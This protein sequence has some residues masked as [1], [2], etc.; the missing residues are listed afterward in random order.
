M[1]QRVR[2]IPANT[3]ALRFNRTA[4]GLSQSAFQV[5][6]ADWWH[7]EYPQDRGTAP[8]RDQTFSNY[9]TGASIPPKTFVRLE[10][11]FASSP[12][13]QNY[14]D[15]VVS[16]FTIAVEQARKH[17]LS[18]YH[19]SQVRSALS[20]NGSQSSQRDRRK[21]FQI[22][23]LNLPHSN[24]I[25][26][27]KKEQTLNTAWSDP[28]VG[29]VSIWGLPGCGKTSL[30]VNWARRTSVCRH[31]LGNPPLSVNWDAI[32]TANDA[33]ILC[34]SFNHQE[35]AEAGYE[36]AIYFLDHAAREWFGVK[37]PPK[38][39]VQLG[40]QLATL[41]REKPALLIL[42]GL[43]TLQIFG[44]IGYGHLKDPGM[45][46]LL[47]QLAVSN[48]GLCICTSLF[49]LTDFEGER[50][51]MFVEL[52]D[53]TPTS[54]GRY[55]WELG[56]HGTTRDLERASISVGNHA[57]S[58]TCLGEYLVEVHD[59]NARA[60][61]LIS[62][63]QENPISDLMQAYEE[64]FLD[65]PELAV[66]YMLSIF[67]CP[68][69][70]RTLEKLRTLFINQYSFE[71]WRAA[72]AHCR[73]LKLIGRYNPGSHDKLTCHPIVRQ[74]F[75]KSLNRSN[76]A[77]WTEAHGRLFECYQSSPNVPVYPNNP[78]DLEPLYLAVTHGCL[79]GRY[80]EAFALLEQRIWRKG[81]DDEYLAEKTL[82]LIEPDL[83]ALRG[84]YE[85][86]WDRLA[87]GL[88]MRD[89]ASLL[90]DTAFRLRAVGRFAEAVRPI[91]L[92]L[93]GYDNLGDKEQ[94]AFTALL[95]SEIY[96]SEGDLLRARAAAEDSVNLSKEA[97][98]AAFLLNSTV[99]LTFIL[100]KLG[101]AIEQKK[102]YN[103]I[104]SMLGEARIEAALVLNPLV[105]PVYCEILLAEGQYDEVIEYASQCL[106]I[107]ESKSWKRAEGSDHF[108]LGRAY[109]MRAIARR[110]REFSLANQEFD[111]ALAILQDSGQMDYVPYPLL[112]RAEMYL[113]EGNVAAARTDIDAA[114][115]IAEPSNMRLHL[116]DCYLAQTRLRIAVGEY[117][118]ISTNLAQ[119]E[120]LIEDTGYHLRDAAV[121]E[122][123]EF[124][125]KYNDA[126]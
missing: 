9:E 89:E 40:T 95:A 15:I 67:S 56:V 122:I 117:E 106:K 62:T 75:S 49:P 42:D 124:L 46:A 125:A 26:R 45:S 17:Y 21:Q 29:L 66:L 86:P 109:L 107:A 22:E 52:P 83:A 81:R 97:S 47:K 50:G 78:S 99:V 37:D 19:R 100:N 72:L 6:F 74:H 113:L 39:P 33:S 70:S 76:H 48:P 16:Q 108:S 59:G 36:S 102:F 105:S 23:R 84:F 25:G 57:F 55:L 8:R 92:A 73:K 11:F 14:K 5:K 12:I 38:D 87:S 32:D 44:G 71:Q 93:N 114:L 126:R 79:A 119:I 118:S 51:V 35:A 24:L 69:D 61:D 80:R 77:L 103:A 27:E 7:N 53:L 1:P 101:D 10:A 31:H 91:Q 68:A 43:E 116:V 34:Y 85:D 60:H 88:D 115:G 54:G 28:R 82:G 13:G 98:S 111:Q 96:I 94:A 110:E 18:L 4:L 20:I 123:Q 121:R 65:K 58:L 120:R 64:W 30:V 90:R 3:E 2:G 63:N 104:R 41:L 112:S